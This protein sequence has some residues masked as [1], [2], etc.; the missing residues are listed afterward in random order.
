MTS[1]ENSK[2]DR[3][4]YTVFTPTYER[5]HTLHRPYESLCEQTFRDFEWLIVDDNSIDETESLIR[6]WQQ[7]AEFPINFVTQPS[8]KQ[9]KHQAFNIG[10][11]HAQ[12]QLFYPLDADDKLLQ[13]SLEILHE[14]WRSIPSSRRSKFVGITGLCIDQD[15]D[16]VGDKFPDEVFD[17]TIL[18]NRYRHRIRGEKSGFMRT[19]VLR[20]HPFPD[21]DG[22]RYVPEAVVWDEIATRY[23]TRYVNE[24]VRVYWQEDSDS[25]LTKSKPSDVALG[26]SLLHKRR[27]N[28]QLNWFQAAPIEFFRSAVHYS[29][30]SFHQ[31]TKICEQRRSLSRDALPIWLLMLPLGVGIYL[32]DRWKAK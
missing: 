22:E 11:E 3:I 6:T 16:I 28:N 31:G 26:H 32:R 13:N 30:F 21:L 1:G 25:Q 17:S 19:D 7:E 8:D 23:C 14:H 15:G 9:G 12:G 2:S 5:A 4:T 10:V 24:V 27:L 20:E 29:R 18:A